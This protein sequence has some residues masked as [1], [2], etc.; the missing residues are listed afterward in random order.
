MGM[1]QCEMGEWIEGVMVECENYA[2]W[3][4]G[5]KGAGDWAGYVCEDHVKELAW[6]EPAGKVT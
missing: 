6:S 2:S 4:G 5:Y 3:Y 1:R